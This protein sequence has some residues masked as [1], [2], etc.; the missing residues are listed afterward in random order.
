MQM[1]PKMKMPGYNFRGCWL[2]V[3]NYNIIMPNS[4]IIFTADVRPTA[5]SMKILFH[6][7]FSLYVRYIMYVHE[8]AHMCKRTYVHAHGYIIVRLFHNITLSFSLLMSL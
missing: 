7:N 5:K 3:Q 2:T 8:C 4:Q 1:A 6:G